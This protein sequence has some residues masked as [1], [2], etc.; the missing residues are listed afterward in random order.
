MVTVAAKLGRSVPCLRPVPCSLH[1]THVPSS[2]DQQSS[3]RGGIP[4]PGWTS[5][6]QQ[7]S[8]WRLTGRGAGQ[9]WALLP[10]GCVTPK[11]SSTMLHLWVKVRTPSQQALGRNH[12]AEPCKAAR[13]VPG[14]WQA[15]S[16]SVSGFQKG[17]LRVTSR[18]GSSSPQPPLKPAEAKVIWGF[19][20][21]GT[22][23]ARED[24]V[25]TGGADNLKE[26]QHW[27]KTQQR[28]HSRKAQGSYLKDLPK[29]E[30][31]HRLLGRSGN[32]SSDCTRPP[33]LSGRPDKSLTRCWLC[34]PER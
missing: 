6:P 5:R 27:I 26:W 9:L 18:Q 17:V 21:Q 14:A 3:S 19:R 4:D 30:K 2:L 25:M 22:A 34:N 7:H 16:K 15:F 12:W 33:F 28:N 23:E 10:T 20:H 29:V 11:E 24:M 13:T 1:D 31:N 32:P 8:D